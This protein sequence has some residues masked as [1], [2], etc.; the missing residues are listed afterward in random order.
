METRYQR[1]RA[2]VGVK[3]TVAVFD[4]LDEISKLVTGGK[5][6]ESEADRIRA[7]FNSKRMT[8]DQIREYVRQK[9]R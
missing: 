9:L 8:P 4:P 1:N 5:I 2:E 6:S 7:D 3:P